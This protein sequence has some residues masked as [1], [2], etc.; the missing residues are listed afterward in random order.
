MAVQDIHNHN[1]DYHLDS[2]A[3]KA[4][5]WLPPFSLACHCSKVSAGFSQSSRTSNWIWV[6]PRN[7]PRPQQTVCTPLNWPISVTCSSQQTH[8]QSQSAQGTFVESWKTL[9]PL[10]P[11]STSWFSRTNEQTVIEYLLACHWY[12]SSTMK[13]TPSHSR[14][15]TSNVIGSVSAPSHQN[16]V[17]K[18]IRRHGSWSGGQVTSKWQVFDWSDSLEWWLKRC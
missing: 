8:R 3:T 11:I 17:S 6:Q 12:T 5:L 2:N 10:L 1:S 18:L 4:P 15:D 13:C 7:L 9:V 16:D 14:W